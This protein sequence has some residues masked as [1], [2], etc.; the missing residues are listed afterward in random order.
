MAWTGNWLTKEIDGLFGLATS[1]NWD[2]FSKRC[3][4]LWCSWTKHCLC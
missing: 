3:K 2:D 1:K 4:K